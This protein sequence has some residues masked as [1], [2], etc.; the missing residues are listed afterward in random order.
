MQS[1]NIGELVSGYALILRI[2]MGELRDQVV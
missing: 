2:S 1:G